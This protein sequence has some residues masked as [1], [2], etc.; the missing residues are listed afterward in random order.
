MIVDR[1]WEIVWRQGKN[2]AHKKDVSAGKRNTEVKRIRPRI[3]PG[4]FA[5]PGNGEII[6]TLVNSR[7]RAMPPPWF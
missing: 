6:G 7:N 3:F 4:R 5:V 2:R 1:Q